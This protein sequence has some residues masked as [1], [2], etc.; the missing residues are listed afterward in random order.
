M[1]SII[2]LHVHSKFSGDTDAE[3]EEIILQAIKLNIDGLA[4]TEHYS[5]EASEAVEMLKER[6]SR[7]IRLFRGVEFSAAEGHCLIFGVNTDK[8]SIRSAPVEYVIRI[9]NEKGGVVIPSHPYR[10]GNSL[11]DMIERTKGICALEGYNGCNMPAYNLKAI[12]AAKALNI[13]FTGGSDAHL[14]QEVGLCYTEFEDAVTEDN[15]VDLLRAG[16]YRGVDKRKLR[17]GWFG[18]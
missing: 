14:P 17:T 9:V 15:F 3:P 2:D 12:K 7:K 18:L 1:K 8:L 10:K 5:Y 16:C 4:F 13:P 11:G 6:Y